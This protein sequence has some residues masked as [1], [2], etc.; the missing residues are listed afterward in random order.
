MA[1][2][3]YCII[4][5]MTDWMENEEISQLASDIV[6]KWPSNEGDGTTDATII[7]ICDEMRQ[8][9][10]SEIDGYIIGRYPGLRDVAT[11][12]SLINKF[13]AQLA[14]Y[15]LLSR[16]GRSNPKWDKIQNDIIV[17]LREIRDG[18]LGIGLEDGG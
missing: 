10:D 13:S 14:I 1:Y 4:S 2:S 9:A 15:N 17:Q 5:D 6:A 18:Q 3:G 8:S 16:R 7:G 11:V 12:P